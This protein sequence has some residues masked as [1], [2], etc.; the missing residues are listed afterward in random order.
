MQPTEL[1]LKLG[2]GNERII[3]GIY[4]IDEEALNELSDEVALSLYKRQYFSAIYAHLASLSQFNRLI[5]LK[6]AQ[7]AEKLVD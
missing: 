6:E 1:K 4:K 5:K 3:N 7:D 2:D